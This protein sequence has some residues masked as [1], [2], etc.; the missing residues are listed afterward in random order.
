MTPTEI[1][2]AVCAKHGSRFLEADDA[3]KCGCA[4]KTVGLNPIYGV[5]HAKCKGTTGWYIWAGEYSED[6]AFF[7]PLCTSH[8][9][10]YFPLTLSY[11]GLAPGYS[12]VIDADGYEDVWYSAEV[13]AKE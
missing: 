7:D 9:A 3:L 2:K 10:D 8:L 1:Q 6:P 12:F 11:L 5:R 13:E 4:I